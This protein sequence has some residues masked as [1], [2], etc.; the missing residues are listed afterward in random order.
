MATIPGLDGRR[1]GWG[2]WAPEARNMAEAGILIVGLFSRHLESQRAFLHSQTPHEA[3][4]EVSSFLLPSN[5]PPGPP[6]GQ[7][8]LGST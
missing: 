6:N 8:Q 7:N 1:V 5:L 3:K 4:I 2:S